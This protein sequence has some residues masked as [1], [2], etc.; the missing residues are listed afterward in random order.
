MLESF[1]GQLP[2]PSYCFVA[3]PS[4]MPHRLSPPERPLRSEWHVDIR[5]PGLQVQLHV[6]E[7]SGRAS[8]QKPQRPLLE[9]VLRC[10]EKPSRTKGPNPACGRGKS[11]V[12]RAQ[13]EVVDLKQE[14]AIACQ[15][16]H[17]A[18]C[19]SRSGVKWAQSPLSRYWAVSWNPFSTE[20]L[21]IYW[22]G[23]STKAH[24]SCTHS[25][26]CTMQR[27]VTHQLHGHFRVPPAEPVIGKF[28]RQ[29]WFQHCESMLPSAIS[30]QR[31]GIE[32]IERSATLKARKSLR[33]VHCVNHGTSC[34]LGLSRTR[35][36]CGTTTSPPSTASQVPTRSAG[37]EFRCFPRRWFTM[38]LAIKKMEAT[39]NL[40]TSL[41]VLQDQYDSGVEMPKAFERFFYGVNRPAA[42]SSSKTAPNTEKQRGS[43]NDTT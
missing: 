31:W 12:R 25:G 41:A 16:Q 27:S 18:M 14:P 8:K 23:T 30:L 40:R 15:H 38:V 10:I 32:L 43:R 28:A 34:S 26:N 24:P 19:A 39:K 4:Q 20:D 33:G 36:W 37:N 5:P 22:L 35:R 17:T 1:P 13:D 6:P 11:T 29:T 3:T 21:A 9:R 2:L 42:R 7:S